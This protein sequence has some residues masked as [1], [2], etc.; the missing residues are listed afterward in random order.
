MIL[1]GLG[2]SVDPKCLAKARVQ[3]I[4][5]I[6]QFMS[7]DA[8]PTPSRT[9]VPP[10][11]GT[12]QQPPWVLRAMEFWWVYI[13]SKLRRY[14]ALL[15]AAWWD[16][17][18]L[19]AWPRF[20]LALP[21]GAIVFGFLEGWTHWTF[22]LVSGEGIIWKIS[23]LGIS[24]PMAVVFAEMLPLL[25]V[26]V[27]LGS[28]SGNL[29]LALVISYAVGDFFFAGHLA[30]PW[31]FANRSPWYSYVHGDI[32]QFTCYLLFLSVAVVPIISAK[33]LAITAHRRV[34][35]WPALKTA[36]MVIVQAFFIYE[37]TF[38]AAMVFR[39]VRVWVGAISGFT[40]PAY[41]SLTVIWLVSAAVVG[42]TLRGWLEQRARKRWAHLTEVRILLTQTEKSLTE[43]R[44]WLRSLLGALV[45]T[46]LTS[47][48]FD[49]KHLVIEG[50]AAYAVVAA[51]LLART[52]GL[53]KFLLWKK[54]S[55][56][57]NRCPA[58]IRLAVATYAS[59]LLALTLLSL[60]GQSASANGIPGAFGVQLEGVG[61]GLLLTLM[62]L[63]DGWRSSQQ[64]R[65]PTFEQATPRAST[66]AS[67]A[68][69]ILTVG[70]L[71]V[72]GSKR[73]FAGWCADP[74]CCCDKDNYVCALLASGFVPTFGY[75]VWGVTGGVTAAGSQAAGAARAYV[76]SRP[77]TCDQLDPS[78]GSTI[79]DW[80]NGSPMDMDTYYWYL[81]VRP[82]SY[83]GGGDPYDLE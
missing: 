32:P 58:L 45:I 71:V 39:V 64:K 18:Y 3:L 62:L 54:W 31:E 59:Y 13:P 53:P 67:I 66:N 79:P 11:A 4:R 42:V 65:L 44:P 27:I 9:A 81:D 70:F 22:A 33:Y 48:F 28:L 49:D 5:K 75:S 74:S 34:R 55:G 30:N 82:C 8:V 47:G 12:T 15:W 80:E 6:G 51:V 19:T 16:G 26:A 7:T 73:A 63:P 50:F 2:T 60:P 78:Q 41:H 36:L 21:I 14:S 83:G 25:V 57:V 46:M 23:G 76:T 17:A 35:E 1:T 43:D 72:L 24:G 29:G 52:Y 61:L 10:N 38:I 56:W 68:R 40:I 20:A 37:W 77:P 69:V